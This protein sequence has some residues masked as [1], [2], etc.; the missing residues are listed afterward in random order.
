VTAKREPPPVRLAAPSPSAI[1][2]FVAVIVACGVGLYLT[3][4]LRD[5]VRLVVIALFLALSLMP[6]IDAL[7]A[8]VRV[9]R[10]AIIVGV[11]VALAGGV[12]LIGTVVVPSMVS[13]VR[14]LSRH[15]PHYVGELRRNGT[16]RRYDDRYHI[17]ARVQSDARAL[18]HRL[19]AATGPLQS[20]TVK[21]FGVVSQAATVLAVAFLLM[22]RGREYADMG[23]RLAGAREARYRRVIADV[24]RAVA[25]YMLGNIAISGLATTA[26]WLVLTILGV[27]YALALGV[28]VGFFDLIPLVGATIGAVIVG[29]ATVPVDFPTA[30]LVWVVF[31]IAYQRVENDLV[32]PLVYGRA[33][34]VN[35]LVTILAVLAGASLLGCSARCWRSPSPRRSRSRCATG[36]PTAPGRSPRCAP[37]K[38][39]LS[40][41]SEGG[42]ARGAKAHHPRA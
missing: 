37:H 38:R 5:V 10:A 40:P 36:G 16:F 23:L 21:A 9:S 28:V 41:C 31:F 14:E 33:L 8:R 42:L 20:V 29:L 7:D 32:Q 6:V 39:P 22:L 27:P 35:P 4:R 11:Y 24:N 3:W 25:Q 2:R 30:T 13:Q 12:V 18:P 34:N 19:A 26:T 1:V 15:A 17:T